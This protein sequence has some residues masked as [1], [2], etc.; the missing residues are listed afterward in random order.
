LTSNG[1]DPSWGSLTGVGFGSQTAN[2]F[3]AAPNGSSGNPSFRT[4][5][6]ADLPASITSN[7]SGNA[8]TATALASAP[9][10]CTGSAFALGIAASG[11]PNC[12]GSQ[13]ANTV[14][15]APNGSA[16]AP[17]FRTI[18]GS[19]LP[20]IAISGGGTGQTSVSAA[21]NALSPLTSEGDLHYY[22]SSSNSRLAI[23][24]ANTFLTSNGTDPSWGSLTGAGFS[25]QT[26][27]T[28]LAAPNGSSGNP[29]FRTLVAADLPSS[30]TSNTSGNAATATVLAATPTQCAGNNLATGIAVSGNANCSQPAFSNLSGSATTS[31]L[32]G[33]G[34][35]TVNGQTCTL[36]S[37]CNVNNGASQYSLAVNGASGAV[38]SGIGPGTAGQIPVSGGASANPSFKDFVASPMV[39]PA[40]NCNNA[41][42]GTGWSLPTS[43]APTVA[44]RTG[45]NVQAG[46]LRFAA[47][48]SAQ[49]QVDIP[50]DWDS[51]STVYAKIYFT[52]GANTTGS[53]T[54][55]MKMAT[56]CSSTTDDP[57]FNTAQA[58]G[59]A[60][61][62]STANM[63][64][65]ETLSS[66]TM[67]SCSA[68]GSLNVQ[69]SRSGS[70]TATTA[71]NVYWVSL[72]FLRLLAAGA[73]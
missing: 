17:T 68:G 72:T 23:G 61:T 42:A 56:G 66:V 50:G 30:I 54:I 52:Q 48:N 58:F 28:F 4:L 41:T 64:Y 51:T 20:T 18:V 44:C 38:I 35:T 60:T 8:A 55:I 13:T 25:S 9:S 1:T 37:T 14:Y 2:T 33:S 11:N 12:I 27:N 39:I 6:A 34:A 31:Q 46:V 24:G 5:V 47:S 65:T 49:F 36:G 16:G 63:P 45:T 10:Q 53:Q 71:P 67:T 3:L 57:S 59:T 32:P 7:T 21:F 26:A 15:A 40:A 22:H 29:S 70:D 62:G 19:D 43:S 69:I 73:N